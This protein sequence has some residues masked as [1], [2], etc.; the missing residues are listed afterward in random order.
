MADL[1]FIRYQILNRVLKDNC[2]EIDLF[3]LQTT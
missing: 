1:E 2:K 3:K